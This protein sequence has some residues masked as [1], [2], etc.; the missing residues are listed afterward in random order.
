MSTLGIVLLVILAV[1]LIAVIV[2]YILGRKMQKKQAQS[3]EQ[4]EAASQSMNFFI[5][6][7]KM[8]KFR[9]ANLPKIV[10]EQ[11][12]KYARRMKLPILKVKVGPRVMSLICDPKVFNTLAP[13]QEV[14]AK[15]SGIYVTSAKRIRGPIVETD[16]KKRKLQKKEEKKAEKA[17]KKAGK[18]AQK[19]K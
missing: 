19:V 1:V 10:M 17:Q 2:L 16:P 6:D 12:P 8:M 15:V 13:K 4:M 14:K 5:I 11:T 7:M 9:D 18:E 3:E